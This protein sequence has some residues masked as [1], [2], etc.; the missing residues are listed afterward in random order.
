MTQIMHKKDLERY[1]FQQGRTPCH[2]I[3]IIQRFKLLNFSNK[4]KILQVDV[5]S[6]I[7]IL[8][9][10]IQ[11]SKF[12][13]PRNVYS[14]QFE[15]QNISQQ[16]SKYC[17]AQDKLY[18]LCRYNISVD[19][20]VM[21]MFEKVKKKIIQNELKRRGKKVC[22]GKSKKNISNMNMYIFFQS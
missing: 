16:I 21:C 2:V 8:S 5:T 7:Q 22:C 13:T 3:H 17:G 9:L 11:I 15:K 6:S 10:S 12:D 1:W 14:R 20:I 19:K 18:I 4:K